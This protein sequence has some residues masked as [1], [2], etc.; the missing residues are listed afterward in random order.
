MAGV[1]GARIA[2]VP[3]VIRE[4]E[5]GATL[6]RVEGVA[7]VTGQ[8]RYTADIALPGLV[9]A[10]VVQSSVG[11]GRVLA[12]DIEAA[13]QAPGVLTVITHHDAP[14]LSPAVVAMNATGTRGSAGTQHLPLQDDVIHHWGQHVA[15]VVAERLE[16]ASYGAS[17][18]RARYAAERPVLDMNEA[19]AA[20]VTPV[21]VWG[22]PPDTRT[23]DLAAG[24]AAAEVRLDATY[25]TPVQ[26]HNSM[27]MHATTAVWDG[28]A[29]TIY[30]PSTWVYGVQKTVAVWFGLFEHQIRVVQQHIGGSFGHKGPTWPHVALAVMAAQRVGRPVRLQLTRAQEFTSVGYRPRIRHRLQLGAT[31]DGRLTAVAHDAVAQTAP[32]DTRVVAPVTATTRKLYACDNVETSYRLVH[33]NRNGPFTMRGPGET[34]GLFAVESA[35][36]ELGYALHMDPVAL[37][38]RNHADVD[39]ETGHPWSSKQ[40]RAC[41]TEAAARFGWAGRDPRPGA[42]RDGD[43][44]VG[45]GMATSAYH[46]KAEKTA[47]RARLAPDAA[48]AYLVTVE[49]ATADPGT[50]ARTI[51]TQIAADALGIA[52]EHVRFRLGDTRLPEAPIAAGSQTTASVGPAVQ[53]ACFALRDKLHALAAGQGSPLGDPNSAGEEGDAFPVYVA[54]LHRAALDSLDATIEV[55]PPEAATKVYTRYSFGAHFC[56]VRVAPN[57]GEVRVSRYVAAFDAGRVMNPR[58]ARSQLEGGIVWGIGQ[59]LSEVT[60]YDSHTGTIANDDLAD[61]LVPVNADIPHLDVWFV[62]SDDPR[63][64]QPVREQGC[65]RDR[66]G[67]GGG[68]RGQRGVPRDGRTRARAA[69]HAGP[70]ALSADAGRK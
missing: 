52:P 1:R 6:T 62:A 2:P 43:V 64:A 44:R 23:G 28:D 13:A 48:G 38:L 10:A 29:L 63:G 27:E 9:H 34:P 19:E 31:S 12:I 11:R 18:V 46:A 41:Y 33:L 16:Q 59:A 15:V 53:A 25:I 32:F 4:S 5:I 36:D 47:A 60:H 50:G 55:A 49:S 22:A 14:R 24:L 26:H 51:M 45:W 20:P 54:V 21:T 66:N 68:G 61:Y 70:A 37:R 17:L 56:E 65:W 39:P 35:M 42:M 7:K 57:T 58:T 8:A 40:L 69:D 30:E 67:R 3:C